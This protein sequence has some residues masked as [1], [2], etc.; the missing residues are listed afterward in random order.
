MTHTAASKM[1]NDVDKAFCRENHKRE[2]SQL[3][4]STLSREFGSVAVSPAVS[5]ALSQVPENS[6]FS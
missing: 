5:S 2:T 3:H 4:I 1:K 6:T